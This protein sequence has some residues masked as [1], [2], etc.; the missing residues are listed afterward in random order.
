MS[1]PSCGRLSL[2]KSALSRLDASVGEWM[3]LLK[4]SQNP[5]DRALL[6][7]LE[8]KVENRE[9]TAYAAARQIMDQL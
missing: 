9:T 2:N 4:L 6:P 5:H 1:A 8:R 3:L 7:N